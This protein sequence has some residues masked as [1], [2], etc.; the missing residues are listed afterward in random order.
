M[1][2]RT[3][4]KRCSPW[5]ASR[6]PRSLAD[7]SDITGAQALEGLRARPPLRDM[8]AAPTPAAQSK[9]PP[10]PAADSEIMATPRRLRKVQDLLLAACRV[11]WR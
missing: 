8:R 2:S 5:A 1:V 10:S 6:C 3:E 7:L 11:R 9:A 4:P